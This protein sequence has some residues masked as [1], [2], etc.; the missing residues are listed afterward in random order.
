MLG[1]VGVA[2]VV[3]YAALNNQ[4]V[5]AQPSALF[6][7]SGQK[8]PGEPHSAYHEFL[9]KLVKIKERLFTSAAREIA[10]EREAYLAEFFERL[11]AEMDGKM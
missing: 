9:F 7:A 10:V 11:A 8:E 2:R 1:A 6:L 3:A 4:P 5:Y